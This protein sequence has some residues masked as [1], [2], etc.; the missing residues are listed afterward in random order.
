MV[1]LNYFFLEHN[2]SEK[3]TDIFFSIS[4]S[5]INTRLVKP[6]SYFDKPETR[7]FKTENNPNHEKT[8]KILN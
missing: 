8:E 2:G 5:Y 7:E 1:I 4:L 6:E 3:D